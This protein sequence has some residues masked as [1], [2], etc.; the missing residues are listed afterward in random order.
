MGKNIKLFLDF[1]LKIILV[2]GF[3]F[4]RDGFD[5]WFNFGRNCIDCNYCGNYFGF[6]ETWWISLSSVLV[7]FDRR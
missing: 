1:L 6:D 7:V 4:D 3:F 2:W 5:C